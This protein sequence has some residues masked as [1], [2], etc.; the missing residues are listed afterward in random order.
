M[1][2]YKIAEIYLKA[3]GLSLAFEPF[4]TDENGGDKTVTLEY[5]QKPFDISEACEKTGHTTFTVYK[6]NDFWIYQSKGRVQPQL[7]VSKDYK[8][9]CAYV[10]QENGGGKIESL[11]RVALECRLVL[12]GVVTLHCACVEISGKAVCLSAASGTG[13]STR[14][15]EMIKALGASLVSG[16]RPLLSPSEKKVYGAPWDGKEMEFRAVSFP[17]YAVCELRRCDKTSARR[18]KSEQAR[19]FLTG[20]SFVPMWDTSLAALAIANVSRLCRELPI[21]RL[22]CPPDRKGAGE[23]YDI[24]FEHPEKILPEAD[25]MKIKN[26]FELKEIMG[27]NIVM[28]TGDNIAKFGGSVVLNDVSAFV[29]KKLCEPISRDD[30]VAAVLGEYNADRQTVEKDIDELL[31]NFKKYG[32]LED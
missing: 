19:R 23:V 9:L 5:A 29:F 10:P 2:Y 31:E 14:A 26:G 30:L 11:I 18:L 28:P 6:M 17:L 7:K 12:E 13:K 27:E 25:D 16:D 21:Y 15:Y 22:M 8:N 20:Q 24:L 3:E 32:I 4:L 1:A